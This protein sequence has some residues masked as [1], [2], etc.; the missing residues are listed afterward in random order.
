MDAI[1]ACRNEEQEKEDLLDQYAKLAEQCAE[2]E[3]QISNQEERRKTIHE[4]LEEHRERKRKQEVEDKKQL[5][6]A[7]K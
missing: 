5:D 3:L 4:T 2:T 6:A 7:K 1:F